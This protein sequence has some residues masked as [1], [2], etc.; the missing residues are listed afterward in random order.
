[1]GS[2][3]SDFDT[4]A[5]DQT[6]HAYAVSPLQTDL[7]PHVP[8]PFGDIRYTADTPICSINEGFSLHPSFLVRVKCDNRILALPWAMITQS[9]VVF[10]AESLPLSPMQKRP[11]ILISL[12]RA[13]TPNKAKHCL[14]ENRTCDRS[15]MCRG[16]GVSQGCTESCS[17]RERKRI[18]GQTHLPSQ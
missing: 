18:L 13:E 9:W 6:L 15:W 11:S 1:M 8:R 3:C 4:S 14:A 10:K 2:P 16:T 5:V 12:S 7:S 17:P